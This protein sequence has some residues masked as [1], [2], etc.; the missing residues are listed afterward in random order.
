VRTTRFNYI[1]NYDPRHKPVPPNCD[2]GPSKTL[3]LDS[4]WKD[5]PVAT[6]EL[7]D[8]VFDPKERR[9]LAIDPSYGPVL[10][11]MRGKLASWMK[12]TNDPLLHGHVPLPP[13]ALVNDMN[14]VSP[15]ET[16]GR[17]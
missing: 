15:K 6:E 16:P 9:N 2:D 7:Y 10:N 8:L 14:G 5:R 3:W 4:G 11:E 13:G 12:N 1:R 17:S